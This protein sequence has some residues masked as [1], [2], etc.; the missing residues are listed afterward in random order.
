MGSAEFRTPEGYIHHG[1][2][3]ADFSDGE[4]STLRWLL[5]ANMAA[6]IPLA[7]AIVVLWLPYQVYVAFGAPMTL[8]TPR[9]P[10][11]VFW[12]LGALMIAASIALHE[13]LHA[14]ALRVLGHRPKLRYV[15]GYF[16]AT[17]QPG[18]YLSRR[19]YLI[20]VLTPLVA[21]TICGGI[22]LFFLPVSIGNALLIAL[23]LNAAASIG[24][25]AVADRVRKLPGT[26]IFSDQGGIQVFLPK[27]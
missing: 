14:L 4:V 18:D 11:S 21:M 19:S 17:I 20:M 26:A 25:L 15:T 13:L 9:W 3:F 23:L 8:P 10:D 24:D 5:W 12:L 1:D 6:L 22:A 2:L 7:V 16:Y 27:P